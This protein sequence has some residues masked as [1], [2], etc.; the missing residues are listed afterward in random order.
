MTVSELNASGSGFRLV[1]VSDCHLPS[2]PDKPYRGLRAD[3]GLEALVP[4]VAAWQPDAV[5]ITGDLSE[6]ASESSYQRLAGYIGELDAPVWALP[7]NHDLP[8]RMQRYFPHGPYMQP[9][10]APCPGAAVYR[11]GAWQLLLL[12]SSRPGRID[13]SIDREQLEQLD[14]QLEPGVPA[15]LALHHQPV[16]IGSPWIDKHRLAQP[17][18]LLGFVADHP[19][20]KMVVW[21]H[22]HQAFETQVGSARYMSCP[23]SAA[24]SLPACERF[25]HDPAGPA[26]RWLELFDDGSF[27]TGIL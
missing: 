22:V 3:T 13:G 18:G 8:E 6:D 4:K 7:G 23:S 15:L 20:I 1:Q 10:A 25:T 11:T 9:K 19:E 26:C 14:R 12:D 2:S 21:G 24:N 16:A 27:E 17:E 5:L